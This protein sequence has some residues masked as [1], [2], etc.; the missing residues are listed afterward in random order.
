MSFSMKSETLNSFSVVV[1]FQSENH[2]YESASHGRAI[3]L[4]GIREIPRPPGYDSVRIKGSLWQSQFPSL[5]GHVVS[6]LSRNFMKGLLTIVYED[7]SLVIL[8]KPGGM[9]VHK[10]DGW[11]RNRRPLMQ[12]IRDQLQQPVFTVHRL[13]R[14]TSGLIVMGKNHDVAAALSHAFRERQVQKTY[15]ALARGYC[16]DS[17]IIDI[18]LARRSGI[19]GGTGEQQLR[20]CVTEFR[21]TARYELP[22]A[23]GRYE[24]NRCS[25]VQLKPRTGRWH[26]LRRH[27][28]RINHPIIG[29]TSHGDNTQNRFY[30]T[31]F[32]LD[33]LMLVA[34]GLE[35]NHPVTNTQLKLEI[36]PDASFQQLVDQIAEYRTDACDFVQ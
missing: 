6:K 10:S 26:Q 30:R 7:S 20:D 1:C 17:G 21:T 16:P 11:D 2:N 34:T 28:N 22:F 3:A 5:T 15:V 32:H 13:D 35:L 29:D 23:C 9:F 24:T 25:L 12:R 31:Q 4:P 14:A 36:T 27:L 19:L 18:P 33:R 8:I